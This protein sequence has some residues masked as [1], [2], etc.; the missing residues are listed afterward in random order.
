MA[1]PLVPNSDKRLNEESYGAVA[2]SDC[3]SIGAVNS[4]RKLFGAGNIHRQIYEKPRGKTFLP[5]ITKT[6]RRF[7]PAQDGR[8]LMMVYAVKVPL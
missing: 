6:G 2:I 1:L 3:N 5:A 8:S 4:L 7:L